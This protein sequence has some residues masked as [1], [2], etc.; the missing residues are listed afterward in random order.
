MANASRHLQRTKRTTTQTGPMKVTTLALTATATV[1]A[2]IALSATAH[3]D[4]SY[5][6]F[7]SPS[8][9][10]VCS[11]GTN[12]DGRSGAGCEIREYT[13]TPPHCEMGMGNE[14]GLNQGNPPTTRCH[15]DTNF[16]PRDPTLPYGQTRSAGPITCDS[17]PV[18]VTC[19]DSSTSHYFFVSR[20][21]YRLG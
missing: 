1:A 5:Y 15:T 2:T 6:Q 12:S 7:V 18:G 20:D 19:T 14:F 10:I 16:D 17:E 11:V 3:A 13:W 21:S 9:N 4:E 8:G